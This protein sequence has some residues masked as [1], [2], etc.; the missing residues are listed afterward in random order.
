MSAL[1]DGTAPLKKKTSWI[2]RILLIAGV[3]TLLLLVVGYFAIPAIVNAKAPGLVKDAAANSIA[4]S[5]SISS[6]Q[7]GWSGPTVIKGATLNDPSGKPVATVD[8]ST[9][10]GIWGL[11]T[12]GSD[13]GTTT[14]SGRADIVRTTDANGQTTSN[15]DAA[16]APKPGAPAQ[17][18]PPAAPG[19]PATLPMGLRVTLKFDKLDITLTEKNATGATTSQTAMNGLAGTATIDASKGPA[20]VVADLTAKFGDAASTTGTLAIKIDSRD[21]TDAAGVL[22]L[23]KATVN[24][25]IAITGAPTALLDAMARQRGVLAAAMGPT[26]NLTVKAQSSGPKAGADITLASANIAADLSLVRDGSRLQARRAST[27]TIQSLAF[28]EKIPA[29]AKALADAG[30]RIDAAGWPGA[31]I[32]IN[33]LN[34]PADD[35]AKW[36]GAAIDLKAQIGAITGQLTRPGSTQPDFLSVQPVTISL[37]SDDMAVA[38]TLSAQ[39]RATIA[40]QSAG[41]ID[42]RV[43]AGSLVGADG[44]LMLSGGRLP[45][46]VAA[47]IS[48]RG[49]ATSL[50]QPFVTAAGQPIELAQDVGPSIDITLSARAAGDAAS[51]PTAAPTAI[52]FALTSSNIN[53]R[54]KLALSST[55]LS[56]AQGEPLTASIRQVGPVLN[57]IL[58][59]GAKD[60]SNTGTPSTL[61]VSGPMPIDLQVSTLNLPLV[62]G[63]PDTANAAIDA[64][65]RIGQSQFTLPTAQ[66]LVVGISD[67][68]IDA[69]VKPK[70]PIALKLSGPLTIDGRSATLASDMQLSGIL[71]AAESS[72]L[73]IVGTRRIEG[74]LSL[75]GIPGTAVQKAALASSSSADLRDLA[76]EL[77]G[78]TLDLSVKFDKSI[79]TATQPIALDITGPQLT[80]KTTTKLAAGEIDQGQTTITSRVSPRAAQAALRLAGQSQSATGSLSLRDT[81]AITIDLRPIRVPLAGATL[82]PD[83]SKTADRQINLTVGLSSP[84]IADGVQVAGRSESFGL[85]DLKVDASI[86]LAMLQPA[87]TTPASTATS[88]L[89]ALLTASLIGANPGDAIAKAKADIRADARTGSADVKLEVS[90]VGTAR[91]DTLIGKPG[92]LSGALGPAAAVTITANRTSTQSPFAIA[93]ALNSE[94]LKVAGIKMTISDTALKLEQ[95]LKLTWQ[96]DPAFIRS[97]VLAPEP[98]QPEG[99]SVEGVTTLEADIRALSISL[100]KAA[101]NGQPASGPLMPGVF[102]ADIAVRSPSVT[103]RSPA[104]AGSPATDPITLSGIDA[105]IT[106]GANSVITVNAGVASIRSGTLEAPQPT[107]LSAQLSSLADARG[108]L[109]PD[110]AVISMNAQTG[111]IPTALLEALAN[112]RGQLEPILGKDLTAKVTLVNFTKQA[113]ATPGSAN[114]ELKS[115]NAG[116]VVGGPLVNGVIVTRASPAGQAA[117]G[118][119]LRAELNEFTFKKGKQIGTA[120]ALNPLGYLGIIGGVERLRDEVNKAPSMVTSPDMEIPIDGDLSKLNGRIDVD[121]GRINLK[122]EQNILSLLDIPALNKAVDRLSNVQQRPVPP[123]AINIDRGVANYKDVQLPIGSYT[124]RA[125]GTVNL[126][127]QQMDVVTYVPTVSLAPGVLASLNK[128][129]GDGFGRLLPKDLTEA[130]MVPIR[131]SGPTADPSTSIDVALMAREFGDRLLRPDNLINAIGDL[132]GGGKKDEPKKN[133]PANEEPKKD[134]PKPEEK[135]TDKPRFPLPFPFPQPK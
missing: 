52:D 7:I 78:D 34:L 18:V 33:T 109:T 38:T 32:A 11:L 79:G 71:G 54:G 107:K 88:P 77:V 69:Q 87:S 21:L 92:L 50:L 115:P 105:Q 75:S 40:N 95:P 89:Q 126:V 57:R 27:V 12:S 122:L 123:F 68:A 127:T 103:L 116:F 16:L 121:L 41:D 3:G 104:K 8:I 72:A 39:A 118:T 85:A 84:I 67:L 58:T 132:L 101:A 13:F 25:D 20:S 100:P 59:A 24:A 35:T 110:A 128:S 42:I 55:S 2:K 43:N 99:M 1:V 113:S 76:S 10:H 17:P 66:P 46:S 125:T 49:V 14:L 80:I 93:G 64:R 9:T 97:Y 47:E 23:D 114:I 111:T 112:Q 19:K 81:S 51:S 22:Q 15:L 91:A 83:W 130:L 129:L 63:K 61:S 4:G 117:T 106:S 124:F 90:D 29:L 60:A 44:K 53:A 37:K 26:A 31:T 131:T 74:T 36:N 119:P 65:V 28:A 133:E 120:S 73:P 30:I 108:N 134:E 86:P 62:S 5:V 96:V 98:G 48:A 45:P 70:L 135:P 82:S 94:R 6:T 56:L 102:A